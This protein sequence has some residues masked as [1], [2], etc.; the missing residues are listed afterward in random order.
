MHYK[1]I[2]PI[3]IAVC[4]S[5]II[6][7][8]IFPN[9]HFDII[10]MILLG[11]AVLAILIPD[12]DK[13]L[14][15]TKKVKFGGVELELHDL[16]KNTERVENE[17]GEEK[18]DT[19]GI[20]K[21]PKNSDLSI[22]LQSDLPTTIL[23]LSIEIEKSLRDI[24][25]IAF[26]TPQQRPFAISKRIDA[27]RQ[28]KIIDEDTAG[29]LRQFWKTRNIVVHGHNSISIT[30]QDMLAFSDIGIRLLKILKTILNNLKEKEA[31]LQG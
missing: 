4:L 18:I 12:L 11:I 5:L 24:Y 2:R 31:R 22:E 29:L 3:I 28:E 9:L 30:E 21:L 10:S 13:V 25:D 15:K 8:I 17:L 1:H 26:Q 20:S 6:L 14:S 7:R 19:S 27:L 16:I 23:R